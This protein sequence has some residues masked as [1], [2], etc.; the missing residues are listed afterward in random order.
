MHSPEKIG[1]GKLECK[2]LECKIVH[3]CSAVLD[4]CNPWSDFGL[5]LLVVI[6]MDSQEQGFASPMGALLLDEF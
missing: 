1:S 6:C 3:L 5:L 4:L 2:I